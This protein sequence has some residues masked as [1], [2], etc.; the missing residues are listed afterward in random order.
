[1]DVTWAMPQSQQKT[2]QTN[3]Q[4]ESIVKESARYVFKVTTNK[5]QMDLNT[6]SSIQRIDNG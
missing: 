3:W 2:K 1:M 6:Y 4:T 5:R